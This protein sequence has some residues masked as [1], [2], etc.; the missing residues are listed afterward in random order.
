MKLAQDV[1]TV[2]GDITPPMGGFGQNPVSD[3]TRFLSLILQIVLVVAGILLLIYL[4]WGALDYI[5]SGGDKEKTTKAQNK[6]VNALI[7]MILLIAAIALFGVV[8]GDILGIIKNT[9]EG[10]QIEIPHL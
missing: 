1:K 6:I 4:F 7:G 5:T 3:L 8:G 9:P 2:I 10:W